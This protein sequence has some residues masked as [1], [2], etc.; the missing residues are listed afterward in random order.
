MMTSDSA[1]SVTKLSCCLINAQSAKTKIAEL[2]FLLQVNKYDI[3][4]VVE[5]W[6]DE[7]VSDGM[8][9]R[10]LPY[11]VYR[12]DRGNRTGG[13][14]AIFYRTFLITDAAVTSTDSEAISLDFLSGN[15]RLLVCYL[16]D[17]R[18]SVLI[19]SMCTFLRS[20]LKPKSNN[21]I[22]GDFNQSFID[23]KHFTTTD[24]AQQIFLDCVLDLGLE[25]LVTKPTRG[26]NILDLV[27]VDSER[28][29]FDT[30]VIEHFSTSDHNSVIFSIHLGE[31][32]RSV[33]TPSQHTRINFELLKNKLSFV[34]WSALLGQIIDV[35]ILWNTFTSLLSRL[36]LESTV[37][38]KLK[39]DR[40][41]KLPKPLIKL[42]VRKKTLWR[43]YKTNKTTINKQLYN[44]C[45][46]EL[47]RG[48][49]G[50][51]VDCEKKV[52]QEGTMAALFR[53][54]KRRTAVKNG[55]P[56]LHFDDTLLL[57]D[58][59]KAN[60]FNCTFCK[61]FTVDN[62]YCP[63][64]S[65]TLPST[66]PSGSNIIENVSFSPHSVRLSLSNLKGSNAIG[67]DGYSATFYK[68]LANELCEPLFIIFNLSFEL[69]I[70]PT[71][72]KMAKVIPVF[73]KGNS[74][75]P[76]NYR[77]I[78]LTCVPCR[79]MERILRDAI[80]K[81]LKQNS[82]LPADQYGFLPGRSTTLQLLNC[83]DDWS[84]SMESGIPVDVILIDFAK[85]FDSVV[86]SKLLAK[87]CNAGIRGRLLS[88]I[89]DFLSSRCQSV[90]V[91][92][93]LSDILPVTSGVPQ[94]SVLG[95]LLFLI[96]ISDLNVPGSNVDLPKFA[97]DVKLYKAVKAPSDSVAL[98]STLH[99][100]K[101]W[102][103]L[104][105]LPINA[106]KCSTFHIGR[107]NENYHY[108]LNDITLESTT[109]IKDLGIWFSLDLKSSYHC[110]Q[111]V[112]RAKKMSFLIRRCFQSKDPRVLI[113]AFCVFVRPI[114]EY[115][116]QVWSPH[117]VKD[118][119]HVESVQR[120][121][122][123]LIP[124]LY[125]K[126]YAERLRCLMLDSLELR[127]LK[128]DLCLTFCILHKLNDSEASR[129]FETRI[130][131]VTRGHPMKLVVRAVKRDCTKYFFS[132]RVVKPWNS[133]PSDVVLSS[134]L[135]Q[136]KRS[137]NLINFDSFLTCFK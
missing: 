44:S 117:L 134:S 124:G 56:P 92:T 26:L 97:D 42:Q 37:V 38:L 125:E 113:W 49:N 103:E 41:L 43:R 29:V 116:S 4:A 87:L 110:T 122:T 114:V 60:A 76:S 106:T 69:G 17:G 39:K 70:L 132:S 58:V 111:I 84:R 128:A 123:K 1:I 10:G 57:A 130:N 109:L 54:V 100:V 129:F 83:L 86:H 112:P 75:D 9:T 95:P 30:D 115:G 82:L 104:W 77:P 91:G 79:L 24:N 66:V 32:V 45:C 20:M 23:W 52:I 133:L 13:G 62:G 102:S 48:I 34:N 27:L 46:K 136:F 80:M 118:I 22:L 131:S 71:L 96:F 99:Y 14:I 85:A 68:A 15:F 137:I 35:N 88:W 12:R 81:F 64:E 36:V 31:G 107:K 50:H 119:I 5:T 33:E 93:A 7:S 90:S 101:D 2:R 65:S 25:Q 72:W 94:G 78:S 16:P 127:R 21:L 61:N 40:S 105:Q 8:L 47:K 121:F 63:I 73:K 120:S 28:F 18:N 6:F 59:E 98:Q 19:N 3:L 108:T 126:S 53:H 51:E 55:I 89:A 74:A 135:S 67:P 11:A